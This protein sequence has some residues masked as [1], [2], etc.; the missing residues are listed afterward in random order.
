MFA[1]PTTTTTPTT[2]L[3]REKGDVSALKSRTQAGALM[4][5]IRRLEGIPE[6]DRTDEERDELKKKKRDLKA[7]QD[8]Q[9]A[10]KFETI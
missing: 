2:T 7:V 3:E 6:P 10:G 8:L 5:Q 9:A 1:S 4:I